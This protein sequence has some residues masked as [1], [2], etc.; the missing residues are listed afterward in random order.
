MLISGYRPQTEMIPAQIYGNM[1]K[2]VAHRQK[3]NAFSAPTTPEGLE[4]KKRGG[5]HR[6]ED[7]TLVRYSQRQNN[8]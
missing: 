3:D 2:L 6:R 5:K 7:G 8:E 4:F 1:I